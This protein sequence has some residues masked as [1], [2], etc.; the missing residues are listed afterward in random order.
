VHEAGHVI[1]ALCH[2]EQQAVQR[3]SILTR[4]RAIATTELRAEEEELLLTESQLRGRL[5]V[6]LAGAVAE[7]LATG[8]IS[9]GVEADLEE[10]TVLARD[11]VARF[12]MAEEV[13]PLRLY[14]PDSSAYLGEETPLADIAPETKAA[15]DQAVRRLMKD[16]QAQA[17][18]ILESHRALLDEFASTLEEHE[19]LEGAALQ[20][21]IDVLQ[22]KLGSAKRGTVRAKGVTSPSK[23][24]RQSARVETSVESTLTS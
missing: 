11:M 7:R 10:A 18:I 21:H 5:A 1:A 23:P 14:G 9:T 3:V 19:T 16:A 20:A 6:K 13:A 12:G 17:Q 22:R 15:L 4:G 2:D 24:R 8:E